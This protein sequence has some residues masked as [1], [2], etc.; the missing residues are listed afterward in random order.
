MVYV[1]GFSESVFVQ[2]KERKKNS[3]LRPKNLHIG[4]LGKKLYRK[5]NYSLKI[6]NLSQMIKS[7][8]LVFTSTDYMKIYYI[9]I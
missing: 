8:I 9:K 3:H 2:K 5:I 4:L 1:A 7:I 6:L